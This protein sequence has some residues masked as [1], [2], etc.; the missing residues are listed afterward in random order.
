MHSIIHH[1]NLLVLLQQLPSELGQNLKEGEVGWSSCR[2]IRVLQGGH[3]DQD[4]V[5]FKI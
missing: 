4:P 1:T 2:I 5:M 3:R